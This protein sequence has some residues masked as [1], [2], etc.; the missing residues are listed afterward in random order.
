M[1]SPAEHGVTSGHLK[2][3]KQGGQQGWDEREGGGSRAADKVGSSDEPG[4]G[5]SSAV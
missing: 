1:R 4:V 3:S 2:V 5:G